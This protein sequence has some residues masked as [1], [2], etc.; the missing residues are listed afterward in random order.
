MYA[1]TGEEWWITWGE[2]V[3][4]TLGRCL[5]SGAFV[6]FD[7]S[8]DLGSGI[9]FGSWLKYKLLRGAGVKL[10]N[11]DEWCRICGDGVVY[12]TGPGCL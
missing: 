10:G 3:E 9:S 8:C 2:N 12:E 5:T 4:C 11:G 7:L 6:G 1:G